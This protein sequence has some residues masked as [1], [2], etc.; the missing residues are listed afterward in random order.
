MN[1]RRRLCLCSL[2][3]V[4]ACSS[5][6]LSAQ[7]ILRFQTTPG[8]IHGTYMLDSEIAIPAAITVSHEGPATSYFI[9][10]SAGQSGKFSARALLNG[11]SVMGYQVYDNLVKRDTLKNLSANPSPSEVLTGSFPCSS[12]FR[13]QTVSF[14]ILILPGQLPPV[15]Q[16]QDT[17]ALELYS[18]SPACHG[19]RR[20]CASFSISVAMNAVMDV[21]LVQQGAPFDVKSSSLTLDSGVLVAG[22]TR[23]ADLIVR[24]N[25]RYTISVFSQNGGT[26]RNPDPADASKVPYRFLAEG[27]SFALPQGTAQPIVSRVSPTPL[28]GTRYGISIIIGETGWATEGTYSD[29]LT[30]QAAAN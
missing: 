26:M 6:G 9:T 12:S 19:A 7:D 4:L 3:V 14:T 30:F 10:F 25:S 13:Q 2:A 29:T 1:L 24:S 20:A 5:P 11:P 28:A 21:S 8:T 16:Y 22:S 27:Q 23:A 18:G 15:G 17:V